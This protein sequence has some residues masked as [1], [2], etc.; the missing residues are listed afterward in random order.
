VHTFAWDNVGFDGPFTFHDL[1]FDAP[2]NDKVN[3]LGTINLGRFS[4]PNQSAV[5]SVPGMPA[6]P[7]AAAVRV[8]FNFF[9][10]TNPATIAV[11][12]NGH[13]HSLAYPYPD[14]LTFTWR[15]IDLQIPLEDL[16]AGTNVVTIGS[17]QAMLTSNVNI[18][19][20]NV[21][22][23]PA[24]TPTL[25]PTPTAT[26]TPQPSATPV[27]TTTP[28]PTAAPSATYIPWPDCE[29]NVRLH[30]PDG[31][32]FESGWHSCFLLQS[33]DPNAQPTIGPVPPAS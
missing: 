20:A 28:A 12:V 16:V 3:A 5:W 15:T 29:V 32:P 1:S 9:D 33:S 25:T 7:T 31:Q 18:V 22:A 17:A 4:G 19:L 11:T 2:D 21:G 26:D 8:L 23:Q 13:A 10:Y 6:S 24:P 27:P 30:G 14:N